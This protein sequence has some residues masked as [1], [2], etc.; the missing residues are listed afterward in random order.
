MC[1]AEPTF[2]LYSPVHVFFSKSIMWGVF[3]FLLSFAANLCALSLIVSGFLVLVKNKVTVDQ[4]YAY[5][6]LRFCSRNILLSISMSLVHMK[7][8]SSSVRYKLVI[9]YT[10]LC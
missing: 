7:P 10:R 3:L 5:H 2:C 6:H 4:K 1:I 8:V 9:Y